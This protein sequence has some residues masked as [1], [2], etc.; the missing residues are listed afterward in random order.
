MWGA[1]AKGPWPL[2]RQAG[3]SGPGSTPQIHS[4]GVFVYWSLPVLLSCSSSRDLRVQITF[5]QTPEPWVQPWAPPASSCAS[6]SSVGHWVRGAG[7]ENRGR[8]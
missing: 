3:E 2:L 7:G 6:C 4:L 8:C 1:G 5:S